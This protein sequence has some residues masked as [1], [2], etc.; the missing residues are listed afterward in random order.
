MKQIILRP[1]ALIYAETI[2]GEKK[3]TQA[4]PGLSK[5]PFWTVSGSFGDFRVNDI[6][7]TV[8]G[9]QSIC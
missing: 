9:S 4:L 5:R 3:M 1:V 2:E 7:F 6:S 8:T